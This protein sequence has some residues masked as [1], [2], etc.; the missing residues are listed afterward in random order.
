MISTR[1]DEL[2]K[3]IDN[4]VEL[5]SVCRSEWCRALESEVDDLEEAL[6]QE[7]QNEI[8]GFPGKLSHLSNKLNQAY[9]NLGPDIHV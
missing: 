2:S 5:T 3:R 9:R 7:F 8:R 6:N 4:A 1:F